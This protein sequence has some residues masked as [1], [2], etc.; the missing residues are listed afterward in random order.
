ML[1]IHC[2]FIPISVL[3]MIFVLVFWLEWKGSLTSVFV[4]YCSVVLSGSRIVSTW[5]MI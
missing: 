2:F 3:C 4:E 5:M 1:Y